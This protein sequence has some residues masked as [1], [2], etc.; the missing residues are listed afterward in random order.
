MAHPVDYTWVWDD[1][2]TGGQTD[3][4]CW[5]PVPPSGYR[6]LGNVFVNGYSKPPLDAV[7]CVK[8][9]LTVRARVGEVIWNDSGGG[10]KYDFAAWQILAPE[11][12]VDD[13]PGSTLAVIAPQAFA[14]AGGYRL[15]ADP[16]EL[17]AL[18][19]P[20]PSGQPGPAP[21]PPRLTGRTRPAQQ[22]PAVT[23]H[24]VRVPL[25]AVRDDAKS[26]AWRV[27]NSPY[28][29]IER[30]VW[31]SLLLFNDNRT[32]S[33][34][35]VEDAV[36]VG[37]EKT[38]SETFRANTGIAVTAEAGVKVF[39]VGA[40]VSA[41]VSAELG[42]ESSTS[43][44]EF[45]SRTVTRRLV[46]PKNTA[47]ALW[48]ASYGLRTVRADGTVAGTQLRFDGDAFHHAQYPDAD[49]QAGGIP[50]H[51][52][53]V[54]KH[55]GKVLAVQ[56][57]SR[58]NGAALIQWDRGADAN[59]KFTLESAGDGYYRLVVK[60]SGK[61]LAVQAASRDDGAALIQWGRGADANEVFRLDTVS[62]GYYR[63]IARHSGKALDV[64]GASTN[65]GTAVVQWSPGTG[66]N[67][68]FRL[69]P[70]P[71]QDW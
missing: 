46:T 66:D 7:M 36:T 33:D 10:G 4:T 23:D 71:D 18:C 45:R 52:R 51:A 57:A 14:A 60:H 2:G 19:L 9:E 32:S 35:T 61:I 26:L 39:G 31:W 6:A 53:L 44:S 16:P 62:D 58:D 1:T 59:E 13:A 65:N 50:P 29:T 56:A 24:S 3:G 41:T 47:G 63:I 64:A 25:T 27:E 49:G 67:Q 69:E 42:Y 34:Q 22:T 11:G 55:S 68:L 8:D 43:V 21:E 48:V 20:L 54:A 15:P 38:S 17:Y 12:S 37:V 40:S 70:I 28:Y 30:R 5:R